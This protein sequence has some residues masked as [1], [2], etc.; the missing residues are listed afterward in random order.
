MY[1]AISSL[2]TQEDWKMQCWRERYG[3]RRFWIVLGPQE[4]ILDQIRDI[5]T[6]PDI[7]S[8]ELSSFFYET[9]SW[10]P[11]INKDTIEEALTTL[12]EKL[13]PIYSD[14]VW[15]NAVYDALARIIEVSDNSYGLAQ[16]VRKNDEALLGS[17]GSMKTC[18]GGE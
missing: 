5:S 15:Q 2:I 3:S 11:V 6:G 14:A 4:G 1:E 13:L 17:T 12:N 9:G 8:L 18:T 7:P 16:A 10:L